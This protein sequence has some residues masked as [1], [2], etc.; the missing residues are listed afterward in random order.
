MCVVLCRKHE[1]SGMKSQNIFTFNSGNHFLQ[2]NS[3]LSLV[4]FLLVVHLA[5]KESFSVL[6]DYLSTVIMHIL[7]HSKIFLHEKKSRCLMIDSDRGN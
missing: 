4:N 3:S 2:N 1:L 5:F 7:H 6:C